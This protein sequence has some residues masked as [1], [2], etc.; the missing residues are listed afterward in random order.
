MKIDHRSLCFEQHTLQ[1]TC[2]LRNEHDLQ[3]DDFIASRLDYFGIIL[4]ASMIKYP[5]YKI[6]PRYQEKY[7]QAILIV[8]AQSISTE[9]Y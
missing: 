6:V 7:Y 9:T 5:Q 3:Q 1:F 8:W 4:G 2:T